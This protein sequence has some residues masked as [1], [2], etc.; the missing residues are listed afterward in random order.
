MVKVSMKYQKLLLIPSKDFEM[1]VRTL[2]EYLG[3]GKVFAAWIT[4]RITRL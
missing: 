2:H 3:I 4:G 1:D